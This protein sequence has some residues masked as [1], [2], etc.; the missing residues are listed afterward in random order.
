MRSIMT[1][2]SAIA[3]MVIA[4]NAQ[5]MITVDFEGVPLTY[6]YA[7]GNTNLGSYYPGLTFGPATTVLEKGVDSGYNYTGYP[8]YSGDAVIHSAVSNIR[9]DFDVPSTYVEAWYTSA[10]TLYLEAYDTSDNLL[11][12]STGSAN[13]GSNSLIS[14]SSPIIAYVKFHDGGFYFSLD[15]LGFVPIPAPGAILLGSIGVGLVGWLR[16]RRML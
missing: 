7:Y 16:R 5:A 8:P 13:Y 15:D 1:V 6:H 14:V 2:C 12:T 10:Y 11:A 9:V 3:L 4:S